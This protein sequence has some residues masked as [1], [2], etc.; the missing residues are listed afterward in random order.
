M[1]N[2]NVNELLLIS[3]QDASV[4]VWWDVNV[5]CQIVNAKNKCQC[6]IRCKPKDEGYQ[7]HAGVIVNARSMMNTDVNEPLDA[8]VNERH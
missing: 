7:C 1:C 6:T 5:G 8:N 3:V 4:H 2:V